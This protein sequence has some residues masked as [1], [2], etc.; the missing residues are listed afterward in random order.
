MISVMKNANSREV[1]K[2]RK[3]V[4]MEKRLPKGVRIFKEGIGF[5]VW[6]GRKFTGSR[7][8][9]RRFLSLEDAEAWIFGQKEASGLEMGTRTLPFPS[10]LLPLP[11]SL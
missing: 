9:K 10:V 4:A 2:S 8:L 3:L 7:E 6:L 1:V 11:R 5:R